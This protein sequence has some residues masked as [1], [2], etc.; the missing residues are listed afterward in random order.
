MGQVSSFQLTISSWGAKAEGMSLFMCMKCN[1]LLTKSLTV[2][3][4]EKPGQRWKAAAGDYT[5][6]DSPSS[7]LC[8]YS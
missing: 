7:T 8:S 5:H 2:L 6:G 1:G 4:R 3:E